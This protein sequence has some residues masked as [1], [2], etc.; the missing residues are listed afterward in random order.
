MRFGMRTGSTSALAVAAFVA[1]LFASLLAAD[2]V[3]ADDDFVP[4]D[5]VKSGD[6]C[7]GRTVFSGT[8]VEEFEIE[9]LGVVRGTAPGTDLIIGRA[10]GA[11]LERTGI[12]EGM[13]G[14]PVYKDG[15]L[16]GAVASTWQFSK[17]PIAGITPIGEMLT[18]LERMD[19]EERS[20][21][22]ASGGGFP[23][24][25]MLPE[26]EKAA[27]ALARIIDEAGMLPLRVAAAVDPAPVAFRDR[28]LVSIAAPLVVSGAAENYLSSV[29]DVLGSRVT[30][31]AG[32]AAGAGRGA[33]VLEP[34]SAVGV[35]FVRGDVNWT[36]I[37]TVTHLEGDRLVAFGHPLFNAGSI[38]MPMVA[39]YVH[40]VMP[41]QSMSFKYA[42]GGELLGT[43]K[44][45][46]NRAVAG[47]V[48]PGPPMVPLTV[49]IRG[50]DGSE[51]RFD[52]EVVNGRPYAALFSGLA[53][54]GTVSSA[55]KASGPVTVELSVRIDTGEELVDYRDVFSTSEP[56]MRCG[57]ELS[58]L[59]SVLT[60]NAFVERELKGVELD[61]AVREGDLWTAIERVDADRTVY[62]PGDEV[63]LRVLLR[64]RRGEPFERELSLRL[65][66]SLPEGAVTL[67]VG[68]ATSFHMWE[69]DRLGFGSAP[70]SY[71]QLLELVRGSK[72]G[73]V[74][75]AQLLSDSPGLSLSGVEMRGVPGR[76]G[77]AM[78][79]SATSGAV[80]PAALSV[81]CER[82]FEV[83]NQAVGY[84]EM[85]IHIEDE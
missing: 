7:I 78:A 56:A 74:V 15:R 82:E 25:G 70:R 6:R 10:E 20:S 79:G 57:G 67:R 22:T 46:R 39:A 80:D 75:V 49:N 28:A 23:G 21:G 50:D 2:A 77:L 34:G 63:G 5:E 30:P 59:L 18:A 13:S 73:N 41:L 64:P 14:S 32:A 37:G 12:M 58:L 81:L 52:F 26:G 1:A 17:E 62:R 40:T 60:E 29:S 27:S 45:D 51:R 48:G 8:G 42:S 76:A 53:F 4:I 72:P 11:V 19:S 66:D 44:E 84:F 36:A 83:E 24:L 54:G 65:P 68:D 31:L 33:R 55:V 3:R 47:V 61:V 69:R 85:S 9:I 35:Q 43:M 71:E 38:D 16:I